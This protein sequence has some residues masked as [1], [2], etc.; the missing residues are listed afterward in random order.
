MSAVYKEIHLAVARPENG[1]VR[2]NLVIDGK[3][4]EFVVSR[5]AAANLVAN[6]AKALAE[7]A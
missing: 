3:T 7:I 2:V 4:E 1:M 6:I 5:T